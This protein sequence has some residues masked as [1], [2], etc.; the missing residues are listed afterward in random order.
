MKWNM[1]A[2]VAIFF[3]GKKHVQLQAPFY[4]RDNTFQFWILQIKSRQFMCGSQKKTVLSKKEYLQFYWNWKEKYCWSMPPAGQEYFAKFLH[5]GASAKKYID[6]KSRLRIF[7]I[8]CSHLNDRPFLCP[9]VKSTRGISAVWGYQKRNTWDMGVFLC[10]SERQLWC[11]L[12]STCHARRSSFLYTTI[13]A[14]VGPLLSLDSATLTI[15]LCVGFR[16]KQTAS[17]F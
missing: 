17:T 9:K 13:W 12:S 15:E 7:R 5:G 11:E 16:A 2:A 8:S 6:L 4:G 3:H 14:L 1:Q 10:R